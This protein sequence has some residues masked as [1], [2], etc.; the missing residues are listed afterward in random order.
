MPTCPPSPRRARGI[1][2]AL[3]LASALGGC[4]GPIDDAWRQID[5]WVLP[6]AVMAPVASRALALRGLLPTLRDRSLRVLNP[7]PDETLAWRLTLGASPYLSTRTIAQ[8]GSCRFRV[9]VRDEAGGEHLLFDHV[10]RPRGRHLAPESAIDLGAFAGREIEL[11]LT[12]SQEEASCRQARWGSPKVIHRGGAPR[13][14][15]GRPNLIL[16]GVDTLR[17]DALGV[18]G[19][20]PS[21][22]PAIDAWAASS[23]L[24][25]QAF[26]SS[27]NTNPSFISLMTGL[28][29]KNHGVYDLASKLDPSYLTLAE[30]LQAAGYRTWGVTAATH[31]G[32]N[33]GLDQGFERLET[34]IGQYFAETV[35]DVGLGWLE[36]PLDDP[37]FLFLHLFDAHVPHNPPARYHLGLRPERNYG[38]L[39]IASWVRFREP[40]PRQFD[41]RARRQIQGHADLYPGEV[42][43][44]DRQVG[45]L[46]DFLASRQLLDT[47]V[48]AL[49]ADHG[50]TLGERGG[51]FDHVGLHDNTTH[52]P[53]IVHWP[54]QT[55][56]RRIDGLVQHFDLFPTVL[57]FLGLAVPSQDG[58]DLLQLAEQGRGRRMVFAQHAGNHGQM[59]RTE[60][61][62]Y[63][64]NRNDPLHPKGI[65]FYDLAADPGETENLAG[66]RPEQEQ[67]LS[68]TLERWLA[69]V[70]PLAAP[71]T[72]QLDDEARRRLEAL[73]YI[74]Q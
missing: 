4:R 21:V 3:F 33:A 61:F 13:P 6:P 5:L 37:F 62:K 22:T 14:R 26:A 60:A 36:Q 59:V 24:W 53:L 74:Q 67:A 51:Y 55:A 73:G 57:G 41:R 30:A 19:R 56:G 35:L 17:A 40:G 23:D 65:Y 46:I 8:G 63:Y 10:D 52:V 25:L 20:Q 49:V 43:Y 64:R 7:G 38:E 69:D 66:T 58:E 47:T 42:A 68:E 72:L 54:G 12:V 71:E 50:E 31:L 44:L 27:N 28:Y 18:Y 29:A 45:R 39:P 1:V 32:A 16:V 9:A 11:A 15:R 70:R 34:P 48:V 2:A